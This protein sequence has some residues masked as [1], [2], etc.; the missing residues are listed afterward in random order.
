MPAI[1]V[2][3]SVTFTPIL[4][5]KSV[6]VVIPGIMGSR[7]KYGTRQVWE[8]TLLEAV[9]GAFARDMKPYL[10]CTESGNF[11]YA[12]TPVNDSKGA[13]DTYSNL[14]RDLRT[15]FE[16][17]TPVIFFPYDWRLNVASSATAL[18]QTVSTYSNV[19]IVAHSMGG[20]V[21]SSYI[22]Q[23]TINKNKVKQLITIGTPFLGA[24]KA[25]GVFE[26]GDLFD[27]FLEYLLMSSHIKEMSTNCTSTYRLLPTS[28]H[29][30]PFIKLIEG[31]TTTSYSYTQAIG[32]LGNRSWA[33]TSSGT[34]KNMMYNAASF[35]NGLIVNGD[36]AANSVPHLYIAGTGQDTKSTAIYRSLIIGNYLSHYENV[37]GDGIVTETSAKNGGNTSVYNAFK[38][39]HIDLTNNSNVIAK[40]KSVLREYLPSLSAITSQSLLQGYSLLENTENN[41][42]PQSNKRITLIVEGANEIEILDKHGRIAF[43]DDE[44][45]CVQDSSLSI[46]KIG[47]VWII[48]HEKNRKQYNLYSNEYTV[49]LADLETKANAIEALVIYSDFGNYTSLESYRDFGNAREVRINIMP[50]KTTISVDTSRMHYAAY[51]SGNSSSLTPSEVWSQKQ[52]DRFNA[53]P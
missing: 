24:T 37:A 15:A 49:T 7:L 23:S 48:N 21:A 29:P 26:N 51:S 20:L 2:R 14:V 53:N 5:G 32:F 22:Q 52:L 42:M 39:D 44:H 13:Q 8:P 45:L 11:I 9:S 25:I 28:R 1:S 47:S 3:V 6:I 50:D 31:S 4:A 46:E 43:E 17:T 12:L 19:F 36:H 27:G 40:V 16:P 10:L 35:H 38:V 33:R 34:T 18:A 41:A 30:S